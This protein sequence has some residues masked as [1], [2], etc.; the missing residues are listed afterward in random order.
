MRAVPY[1]FK[2]I[3]L[4][5]SYFK[6]SELQKIIEE[7]LESGQDCVKIEDYN[8]KDATVCASSLNLAVKRYKMTGAKAISRNGE[9][10]LVKT[11]LLK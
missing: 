5:K 11:S 9:V 8:H 10:F 6:K 4:K 7:F 3:E 1:D 2:K